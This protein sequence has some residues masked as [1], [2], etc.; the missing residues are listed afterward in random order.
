MELIILVVGMQIKDTVK[1]NLRDLM[2]ISIEVV[3]KMTANM[4]RVRK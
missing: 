2:A 4:V 3:G 1:E